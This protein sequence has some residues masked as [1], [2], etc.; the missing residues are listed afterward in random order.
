MGDV[1]ASH[2]QIGLDYTAQLTSNDAS[3]SDAGWVAEGEPSAREMTC[4]RAL[5]EPM[6][7]KFVPGMP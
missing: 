1:V 7:A 5:I 6:F 2:C 4:K 3:A